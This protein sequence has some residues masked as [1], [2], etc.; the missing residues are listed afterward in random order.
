MI[1][2]RIASLALAFMAALFTGCPPEIAVQ[3]TLDYAGIKFAAREFW[4][5]AV[6]NYW[7]WM[8]P[9][10][11][12]DWFSKKVIKSQELGGVDVFLV[13][14]T[15]HIG[16]GPVWAQRYIVAHTKGLYTAVSKDR[17]YEWAETPDDLSLLVPLLTGEFIKGNLPYP[18]AYDENREYTVAELGELSPFDRCSADDPDVVNG[19]PEDFLVLP[20]HTVLLTHAAGICPDATRERITYGSYALGIGPLIWPGWRRGTLVRAIVDGY[21][22]AME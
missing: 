12:N 6:G 4:P 13:E 18:A 20:D 2:R 5:L 10:N 14:T 17:L 16:G 9:E 1:L 15:N 7:L 21:E 8:D 22:F 3:P 11:T 19:G